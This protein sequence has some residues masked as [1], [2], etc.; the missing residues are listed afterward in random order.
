MSTR[1]LWIPDGAKNVNSPIRPL[2]V[3]ENMGGH[4]TMPMAIR[5]ALSGY[6][7]VRP[8]FLDVPNAGFVRRLGA[9]SIPGLAREDFDLQ[10]LR[11][12]LGNS[13]HVERRLRSWINPYDVLHVYSQNS[14]LLSSKALAGRP[15]VVATDSTG[16]QGARILPERRVGKGTKSRIALTKLFEKKVYESATLVIAQS[17]WTANS[18]RTDYGVSDE[19]IRIVPFGINVHEPLPQVS[20]ALPQ[21]TFVGT[22]L[23]RKGG[24]RLLDIWRRHL[25]TETTLTLV[26]RDDVKLQPGLRVFQDFRP[27]DPRL[28]TLLAATDLFVFPSE[29]DTFGYALIEAMAGEVATISL[30]VAARAEIAI[31]GV[32][33]LVLPE[34][35]DDGALLAGIREL[36]S[37]PVRSREMGLA[38][39][40]RVLEHFDARITTKTLVEVLREAQKIFADG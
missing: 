11:I 3:N 4:A 27:G 23:S 14:A 33:G 19:R 28:D 35:A 9:V 29:I 22:R 10:A 13:A 31:D 1:R 34:G 15:S 18:L 30:A 7:E 37:D 6:P 25:S 26:T 24:D 39:R 17:E 2:F 16:E 21:I 38:G 36:L 5:S 32:T 12:Q 20:N 8:Q 40:Q